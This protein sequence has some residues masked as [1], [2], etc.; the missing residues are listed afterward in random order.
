VPAVGD[1][2]FEAGFVI[3][4]VVYLAWHALARGSARRAPAAPVMPGR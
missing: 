2:T 1:I 4:G 3:T